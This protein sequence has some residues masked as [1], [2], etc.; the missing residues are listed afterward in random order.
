MAKS[1]IWDNVRIEEWPTNTY[2]RLPPY[3]R[4]YG[5]R[6]VADFNGIELRGH[7]HSSRIATVVDAKKA[8][9]GWEDVA[10]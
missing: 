4:L 10:V 6:I 9:P 5:Y 3:E 7:E 2:S 8:F 1:R